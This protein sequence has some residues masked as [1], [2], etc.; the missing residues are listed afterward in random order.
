MMRSKN[1]WSLA[2]RRPDKSISTNVYSATHRK[3]YPFLGWP[4]IRGTVSLIENMSIGFKALSF[5]VNEATEEEVKFSKKEFA[6]SIILAV[7]FTVGIFFVL[8]D[9]HRKD[10]LAQTSAVP[11]CIILLKVS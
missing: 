9:N 2:V 1:F 4:F 10:L 5:S 7:I 8:P 3:K 6:I 11:S